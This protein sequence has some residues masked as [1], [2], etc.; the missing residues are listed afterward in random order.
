MASF[1]SEK[2]VGIIYTLASITSIL[3]LVLAPAIFKKIGGY[4]F[5]LVATLLDALGL[6]AFSFVNNTYLAIILFVLGLALNTLIIFTLDEFLKIFSENN[7]TGKIRGGYIAI[8]NIAWIIS[9]L[10]RGTILSDY[11]LRDL[12]LLSFVIMLVFLF[13]SAFKFRTLPDPIYDQESVFVYMRKFFQNSNLTRAYILNTL[14]QFFFSWMIVYTPIYLR[15]HLGFAWSEIGLIFAFMLL[16]LSIVPFHLG[17]YGDHVG[18]RNLLMTGFMIISLST[19]SI[20]FISIHSIIV[21]AGILFLTRVGAATIEVMNDSYFFKHI[22]SENDEFISVYRSSAPLA[23][24][25]GPIVAFIT[26]LLVPEFNYL[27]L[28]LGVIMAV[29]IYISSGIKIQTAK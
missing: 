15:A 25:I 5:L 16:P 12:Y 8:C 18:E 17:R 28:T 14:L 11:S 10:A 26:F 7:A 23:Y 2:W 21:W 13:V 9:Q 22:K 6:L 4:K 24:I 3:A 29:G 1:V 20:F 19:I 27:Y